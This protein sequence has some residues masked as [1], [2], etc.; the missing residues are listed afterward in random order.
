MN[1]RLEMQSYFCKYTN[2]L[3]HINVHLDDGAVLEDVLKFVPAIP[4]DEIGFAAI[5][6]IKRDWS[7]H[8]K[9]GDRVKL[10]TAII[11]E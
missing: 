11:T 9:D 6:G 2:T 4:R 7:N 10:Y 3:E 1:I 8:L 5:N